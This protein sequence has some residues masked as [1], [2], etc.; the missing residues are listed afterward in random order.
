MEGFDAARNAL[1]I[2]LVLSLACSDRG[3]EVRFGSMHPAEA[4]C[5]SKSGESAE[6]GACAESD[7]QRG[8]YEQ[9]EFFGKHIFLLLAREYAKGNG[10]HMRERMG[11]CSDR[12]TDRTTSL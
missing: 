7:A 3:S 8:S 12:W 2:L 6:H 5:E 9:W 1:L 4:M 11:M 10:G